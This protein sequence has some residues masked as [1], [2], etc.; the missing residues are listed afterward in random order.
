MNF[1]RG[2]PDIEAVWD[3]IRTDLIDRQVKIE[4]EIRADER[5]RIADRLEKR[6]MSHM[7]EPA[8]LLRDAAELIRKGK[9]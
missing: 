9:L 2:E 1:E 7:A 5:K 6:A 3:R 4:Q 8:Y